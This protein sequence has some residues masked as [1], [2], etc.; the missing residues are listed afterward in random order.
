MATGNVGTPRPRDWV[1]LP[2]G[3][4]SLS[5]RSRL[6]RGKRSLTSRTPASVSASAATAF[7]STLPTAWVCDTS[8]RATS[9]KLVRR[10]SPEISLHVCQRLG[11]RAVRQLEQKALQQF[12]AVLVHCDL[13]EVGGLRCC[14]HALGFLQQEAQTHF[15]VVP[16]R[17]KHLR[18]TEAGLVV[19]GE[20]ALLN[21]RGRF[22]GGG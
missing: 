19:H 16:L 12:A 3:A 14:G 9:H 13:G 22:G 1:V 8:N 5:A 17:R 7:I 18:H 15:T 20:S 2:A 11:S 10:S 4:L 21:L 6:L